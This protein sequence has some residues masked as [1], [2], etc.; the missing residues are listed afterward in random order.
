MS[1]ELTIE[2]ATSGSRVRLRSDES[3]ATNAIACLRSCLKA[4]ALCMAGLSIALSLIVLSCTV[5]AAE[6]VACQTGAAAEDAYAAPVDRG[7]ALGALLAALSRCGR[8][9]GSRPALENSG[10]PEWSGKCRWRLPCIHDNALLRADGLDEGRADDAAGLADGEYGVSW[11]VRREL[12]LRVGANIAAHGVRVA[13]F[14]P[15]RLSRSLP[16][17]EFPRFAE[18]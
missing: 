14:C 17:L 4:S 11:I 5:R 15:S 1:L 9:S 18:S 8:R 16:V 12:C 10:S 2:L 13:P 7:L 3:F 6:A